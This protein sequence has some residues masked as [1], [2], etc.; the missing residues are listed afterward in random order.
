M[1]FN[2]TDKEDNMLKDGEKGAILQRDKETYAIAPHLPCGV[3]S[4]ETLRKIADT[5][6][7][8]NCAALKVTSAARIAMVGIKEEDIDQVWA[9]LG[10]APGAAVGLCVRS[11]KVCPGTAFC[12]L[13]QQD[14]LG[15]G[16]KLD[17]IYHGMEF[18]SKTKMGVSGCNNQCAENCIK[19]VSLVGKKSGWTL[20]V[21]GCGTGKPRLADVLEEGLSTEDALKRI[22]KV[23]TYYKENANKG[24]RVG[25]MID[26]IGFDAFRSAVMG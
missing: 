19:D 17:E 14:S 26:R 1:R 7:K 3:V 13:A 15:V 21:G 6:E 22:D 18:P 4:P 11:V 9:E 12:K 5:A 16:M 24:E 8:F 10:M 23:L 2:A 25:K 20:M